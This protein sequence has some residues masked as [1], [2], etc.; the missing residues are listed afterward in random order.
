MPNS[1]LIA[2]IAFIIGVIIGGLILWLILRQKIALLEEKF[3]LSANSYQSIIENYKEIISKTQQEL[4]NQENYYKE[5]IDILESRFEDSLSYEKNRALSKQEQLENEFSIK[6]ENLKEKIE[7]LENSKERLK[8]EFENLANK[9]FEEN[10]KKST[11]NLTQLL[12][13]FKDQLSNFG[14]RVDDIYNE[15]TKQRVSLLTEIKNLKSLN[16][17]ISQDAINLTKALKG[18]NKPKGI[19]EN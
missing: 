5:K 17:Q 4:E 14:K 18:E 7:L 13:P 2:I 11:N 10:A 15:E 12:T 6:E 9:L 1:E 8:G 3:S 19:G 16:Q